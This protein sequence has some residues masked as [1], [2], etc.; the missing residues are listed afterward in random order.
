MYYLKLEM[1]EFDEL[2]NQMNELPNSPDG[3]YQAAFLFCITFE[4]PEAASEAGMFRGYIASNRF[5]PSLLSPV[6]I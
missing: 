3:A 4:C 1:E 5:Y 6:P 2:R